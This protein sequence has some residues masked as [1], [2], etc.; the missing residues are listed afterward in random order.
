MPL[1]RQVDRSSAEQRLTWRSL[2]G[3]NRPLP[4][5]LPGTKLKAGEGAHLV[6]RL[7]EFPRSP[8]VVGD[9]TDKRQISN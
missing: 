8:V 1:I 6:R 7:L 5:A 2:S 9:V 4:F 3:R